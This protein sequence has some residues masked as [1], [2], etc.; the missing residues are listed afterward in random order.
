MILYRNNTIK[1]CDLIKNFIKEEGD[2]H[3]SKNEHGGHV[4]YWK[5]WV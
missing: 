5:D 1:C 4:G 3:G 2:Y